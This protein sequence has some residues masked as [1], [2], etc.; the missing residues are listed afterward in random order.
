MFL[1]DGNVLRFFRLH[2]LYTDVTYRNADA[3]MQHKDSTLNLLFYLTISSLSPQNS[4][5]CDRYRRGNTTWCLLTSGIDHLASLD[6]D[7]SHGK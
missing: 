4:A 1:T 6:N 2:T 3:A 7:R 5:L